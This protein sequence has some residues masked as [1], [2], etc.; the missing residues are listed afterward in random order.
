MKELL[1]QLVARS[2][3]L[4][5]EEEGIALVFALLATTALAIMTTSVLVFSAE[6]SH[7]SSR[8]DADQQAYALAEAGINTAVAR[9]YAAAD[10]TGRTQT[11]LH[12]GTVGDPATLVPQCGVGTNVNEQPNCYASGSVAYSGTIDTTHGNTWFWTI[13]STG[14]VPVSGV[15]T[16]VRKLTR[17]VGVTGNNGTN[18]SSWT[19]FYQD[20]TSKCLTLDGVSVPVNFA[21]RGDICLIDGAKVTGATTNIN[22]GGNIYV[23]NPPDVETAST[24]SNN[25]GWTNSTYAEVNDANRA[26]TSSLGNTVVSANLDL[27]NFGITLPTM[28]TITGIK[29]S[30]VRK[31]SVSTSTNHINDYHV[32]LIKAGA[33]SG[34]DKALTATNW[35]TADA[36]QD[37]GAANDLW[38]T[39]WT[40]SQVN[41]SNF[42]VRIVAKSTCTTCGLTAYV[43]AVTVTVYF[44]TGASV[45]VSGTPILEADV[46]GGCNLSYTTTHN[47]CTS[48]DK[49]YATTVKTVAPVD[50]PA[51]TMPDIDWDY[52]WANAMPGPKHFCTNSNPGIATNFF[53]NNAS[54]TTKPDASLSVNGEMAPIGQPYDC[55]VWV[56]GVLQGMMK[57][58]GAHRMDIY[59]TIFV[60]GNFRWDNDGLIVHYFGRATLMSSHDDEIDSLVCAGGS[61]NTYAT[62]CLSNMSS[63]SPSQNMIVLMS[64]CLKG[65]P[66]N[67]YDQGGTGCSGNT[68]PSCYNGHLPGGFQG[69]LYSKGDCLIHQNF[70]DSGPVICDTITMPNEGYVDPTFF[71]FPSV[72]NL[73]NGMSYS[74]TATATDWTVNVSAQG[75]G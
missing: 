9:I 17:Q 29:V 35:P 75:D 64:E 72:G 54:T 33:T 70:Q 2:K 73:T 12:A 31:A 37:Y 18:G 52:W 41:A 60:D 74:D 66:C 59:G 47:P 24:A 50:N 30:I 62:S 27:S 20:S 51:I 11:V 14:K 3:R 61:G 48:A 43:N 28:A 23:D 19:R 34:T 6:S 63:W 71:P 65:S 38:G 7:T 68:P 40:Y 4:L 8:T 32:Q 25:V 10:P 67:E 15:S 21:S 22:A 1:R 69:I 5:A 56:N 57:W 39:T 49:V 16:V 36:N 13:T 46:G 45:G 55:E 26:N 42:G 58:D 53:D 44:T